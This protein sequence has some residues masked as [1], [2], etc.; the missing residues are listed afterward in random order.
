MF[1]Y[2]TVNRKQLSPQELEAYRACYCGVCHALRQRYGSQAR[3]VLSFDLTFVALLLTALYDQEPSLL[4][5]HRC[6]FHPFQSL[7]RRSSRFVEYGADMSVLLSYYQ[8][9]DHWQDEGNRA[10]RRQA[11]QL[12]AGFVRL[13]AAYPRQFQAAAD[14]VTNLAALERQGEED[15]DRVANL[16]GRMLREIL[17]YREDEWAGV[18]GR[19]GFFLGK[20]IYIMDA[21][22]DLERDRKQGCYN[23][24]LALSVQP[25]FHDY[26]QDLLTDLMAQATLAFER[27]PILEEGDPYAGL[28]RNV[29]YAGVWTRYDW[30]RKK[31]KQ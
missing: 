20:F 16:T 2:I 7:P 10:A 5:R 12:Q 27:L 28:L 29:L 17:I 8:Y 18:L 6:P 1:G 24:L 15:L 4:E 19:I 22:E 3:M 11:E 9:L 30:I 14:Y 21:Y 31:R 13:E 23:P 26:C 25:G